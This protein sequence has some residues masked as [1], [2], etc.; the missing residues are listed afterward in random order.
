L[1]HQ[2]GRARVADAEVSLEQRDGDVGFGPHKDVAFDGFSDIGLKL[3]ET[4]VNLVMWGILPRVSL[5]VCR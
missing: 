1:L 2:P 5:A 3:R 4:R